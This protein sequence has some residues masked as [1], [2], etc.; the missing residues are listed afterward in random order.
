[1]RT[2]KLDNIY[3]KINRYTSQVQIHDTAAATCKSSKVERASASL[4]NGCF[5]HTDRVLVALQNRI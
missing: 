2:V 5:R 4:L 1:M 3:K